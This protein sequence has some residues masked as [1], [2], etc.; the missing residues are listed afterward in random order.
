MRTL[1]AATRLA[2]SASNET[3][4]V[5]GRSIQDAA[6]AH[7]RAAAAHRLAVSEGEAVLRAM[8]ARHAEVHEQAAA[9]LRAMQPDVNDVKNAGP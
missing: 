6:I 8:H 9:R 3:S 1:A 5:H 7:D 4:Y 2:L